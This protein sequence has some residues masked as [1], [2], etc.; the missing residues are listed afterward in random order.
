MIEVQPIGWWN[1]GFPLI[2][3]VALAVGLPLLLAPSGT[4]SQAGLALA[5][6][7]AVAVLQLAGAALFAA[8]YGWRGADLAASFA[9]APT[10]TAGFFLPL[11]GYAALIWGPVLARVWLGL[12][13]RV[14][15]RKGDD[16]ARKAGR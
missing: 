3:L 14:E 5:M 16:A 15:R 10:A 9:A 2:C 6:L 7:V 13:Q 1:T 4:R 11:A 12:A 8:V